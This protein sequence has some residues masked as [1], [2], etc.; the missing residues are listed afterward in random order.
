M[1]AVLVPLLATHSGPVAESARPHGLTSAGSV[2]GALPAT[3]EIRSTS[4]N[5]AWAVSASGSAPAGTDTSGTA[6]A[7]A[8]KSAIRL[9]N[10]E[11]SMPKTPPG[12]GFDYWDINQYASGLQL[13]HCPHATDQRVLVAYRPSRRASSLRLLSTGNIGQFDGAP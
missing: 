7:T 3:S 9:V 6:S 8:A 13:D 12:K 4:V 1:V 5:A 11:M 10:G 2:S